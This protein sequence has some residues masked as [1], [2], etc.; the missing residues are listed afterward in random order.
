VESNVIDSGTVR[1]PVPPIGIFALNLGSYV[2]AHNSIHARWAT[3]EAW[4]IQISSITP[5]WPITGAVVVGN[6]VSMEA[7]EGTIFLARSAAIAIRGNMG[8][9]A[10]GNVVLNNRIRGRARAA[11]AVELGGLGSAATNNT[12]V[13]NRFDDFEASLAD[14][15]VSDGV[16]NTFIAGQGTV[17]DH[18]VGTVIE[19][20]PTHGSRRGEGRREQK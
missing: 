10:Q 15:F 11:L 16:M 2:I 12:F 13:L 19:P 18:G 1:G 6:H 17:E 4:G 5:A 20:L 7:P 9:A 3:G 14:I 8:G